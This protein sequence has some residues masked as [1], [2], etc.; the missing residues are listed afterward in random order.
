MVRKFITCACEVH[1]FELVEL[2]SMD[3]LTIGS[4]AI[5]NIFEVTHIPEGNFE[6]LIKQHT[7]HFGGRATNVTAISAKLGLKTGIISPVGDDFVISGYENHLI[8]LGVDLRGIT[9]VKGKKTV[10][11][12][13]FLGDDGEQITFCYSELTDYW[14][15]MVV[16]VELIQESQMIH[17]TTS[18]DFHI[19]IECA[20]L[21]YKKKKV[22]SFDPGNDP[23]AEKKEYLENIMPYVSLLFVNDLELKKYLRVLG[24][25]NVHELH[26]IGPYVV[27]AVSSSPDKPTTVYTKEKHI[28]FKLPTLGRV[29]LVGV[30]D[31]FVAGFIAAHLKG[32]SLKDCGTIGATLTSFIRRGKSIQYDIPSWDQLIVEAELENRKKMV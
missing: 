30:T 8:K 20:R 26:S 21:A 14:K 6:A 23:M 16:P 11:I 1:K 32:Y 13:I 15:R 31:A 9:R 10:Q 17:V 18:G 7:V 25:S 28:K 29:S 4:V 2:Q 22:V 24:L 19:G 5:D 3:L 12:F 27:T